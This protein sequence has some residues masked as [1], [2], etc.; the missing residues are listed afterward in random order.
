MVV[1]L[2]EEP[3]FGDI[4][5]GDIDCGDINCGDIEFRDIVFNVFSELFG[6]VDKFGF[7]RIVFCSKFLTSVE[8]FVLGSN[9]EYEFS[10][11]KFEGSE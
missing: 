3:E 7:L 8:F 10:L 4:E 6:E 5:C 11:F 1:E 2:F 9:S